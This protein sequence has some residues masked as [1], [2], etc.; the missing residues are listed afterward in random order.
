[1]PMQTLETARLRICSFTMEDIDA[2]HQEVY[3]S[4]GVSCETCLSK[5]QTSAGNTIVDD[6]GRVGDA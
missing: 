2:A 1:M 3:A 4:A 5:L 6:D